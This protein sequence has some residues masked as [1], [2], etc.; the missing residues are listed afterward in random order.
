MNVL[1]VA[2]GGALGAV[3]RYGL[4][5]LLRPHSP[6]WPLGT[7]IVNLIGCLAIGVIGGAGQHVLSPRA[8]SRVWA[9][10]VI[11]ILGGFTTF[12]SFGLETVELVQ[13]G[14]M[15]S[16]VAY[17]ALS[18]VVGLGLAWAGYVLGVKFA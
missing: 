13:E 8:D 11:G 15:A 2:L 4:V 14:R 3:G 1:L 7:L 12:S 17:I 5:L 6:G 18:N 10:A 16:A 9:F